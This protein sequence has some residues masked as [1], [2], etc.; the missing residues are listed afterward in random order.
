M[1]KRSISMVVDQSQQRSVAIVFFSVV[2]IITLVAVF[3]SPSSSLRTS[4]SMD[5]RRNILRLRS[6]HLS[7]PSRA[8]AAVLEK[9]ELSSTTSDDLLLNHN[10]TIHSFHPHSFHLP[11]TNRTCSS[12]YFKYGQ[13]IRGA[14]KCGLYKHYPNSAI[15]DDNNIPPNFG[16]EYISGDWCWK[17]YGCEVQKFN[18][19]LFCEKL[20]GRRVLVVGDSIQHQ[21]YLAFHKLINS[22]RD[23]MSQWNGYPPNSE[24]GLIC[25]DLG[26]GRLHYIRSDQMAVENVSPWNLHRQ[27]PRVTDRDWAAIA[28]NFDILVLNK[29]AHYVPVEESVAATRKTAEFLQTYLAK[30]K[31]RQVFFRTTPQGAA[32]CTNQSVANTT[33]LLSEPTWLIGVNESDPA[34]IQRYV[35]EYNWDKF[36][37]TNRATVTLL[38]NSLPSNQ[39]TVIHVAEMT[40]LR[41][42][43]HRCYS[44]F[45]ECDELHFFLPSVVDTWV[46]VMFNLLRNPH[47]HHHFG[48]TSGNN[49]ERHHHHLSAKHMEKQ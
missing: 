48:N 25:E 12:D 46:Y 17:P 42:D 43:G 23:G 36:P 47:H 27:M 21:F 45:E 33:L 10:Y 34:D 5:E 35:Q 40:A 4:S 26:G 11:I 13:W 41:P 9:R 29:G 30:D 44:R 7:S 31:N 28:D 19:T 14:E 8:V 32:H 37:L 16:E 24:Q 22:T 6:A 15:E 20:A 3:S 49:N 38:R 18:R 1:K 39:F 2:V